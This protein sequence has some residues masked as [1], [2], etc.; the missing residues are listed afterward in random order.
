VIRTVTGGY[1]FQLPEQVGLVRSLLGALSMLLYSDETNSSIIPDA[2]FS[3][4]KLVEREQLSTLQEV[5]AI[6]TLP[7]V[8]VDLLTVSES[9]DELHYAAVALTHLASGEQA[10]IDTLLSLGILQPIS[11]LLDSKHKDVVT[12]VCGC[13]SNICA[14]DTKTLQLVM[15]ANFFEQLIFLAMRSNNSDAQEFA[16]YAV[17]FATHGADLKQTQFLVDADVLP[18][19][20]GALRDTNL[21][22]VSEAL[23]SLEIVCSKFKHR[24]DFDYVSQMVQASKG[25]DAVNYLKHSD[26]AQVRKLALQCTYEML[27]SNYDK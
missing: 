14:G 15:E 22:V 9:K 1:R 6:P 20:C 5:F 7:S 25:W 19:V 3:L 16:R 13:L 23:K 24:S 27:L 21:E 11:L 4:A 18:V 17:M 12:G 8:L 2:V 10:H 26:D